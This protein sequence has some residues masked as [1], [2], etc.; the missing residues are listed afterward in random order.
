MIV[1]QQSPSTQRRHTLAL[2]ASFTNVANCAANNTLQAIHRKVE[3]KPWGLPR[4][5]L[6]VQAEGPDAYSGQRLTAI[7]SRA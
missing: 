5:G 2:I 1:P 3:L 7:V 4:S 6:S